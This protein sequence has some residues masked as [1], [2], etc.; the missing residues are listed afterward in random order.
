MEPLFSRQF[1]PA[2]ELTRPVNRYS[3]NERQNWLNCCQHVDSVEKLMSQILL[4]NA[5]EANGPKCGDFLEAEV[6][7]E[8]GAHFRLVILNISA[9]ERR[10]LV[11]KP[12]STAARRLLRKWM[13]AGVLPWAASYEWQRLIHWSRSDP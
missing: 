3:Y 10:S 2:S 8:S 6:V 13:V 1:E 11:A 9:N 4:R 12:A 7:Q 5:S